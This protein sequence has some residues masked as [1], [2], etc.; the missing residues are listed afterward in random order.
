MKKI[1]LSL[2]NEEKEGLTPEFQEYAMLK[3]LLQRIAPHCRRDTRFFY[4]ADEPKKKVAIYDSKL[5]YDEKTTNEVACKNICKF[6]AQQLALNGINSRIVSC[7]SDRCRH[8]DLLLITKSGKTILFNPLESLELVQTHMLTTVNSDQQYYED[9]YAKFEKIDNPQYIPFDI[10][11]ISDEDKIH[12]ILEKDLFNPNILKT[13]LNRRISIEEGDTRKIDKNIGYGL[14]TDDKLNLINETIKQIRMENGDNELTTQM[15]LQTIL[16][17]FPELQNIKGH[18]DLVMYLSRILLPKVLTPEDRKRISRYDL[19]L[20]ENSEKEIEDLN[21]DLGPDG[22]ARGIV[23]KCGDKTYLRTPRAYKELDEKKLQELLKKAQF[24]KAKRLGI[25]DP[26]RNRGIALPVLFTNE[27]QERLGAIE[28]YI[29]DN[30][31]E[32]EK[33]NAIASIANFVKTVKTDNS[34]YI[35]I[36]DIRYLIE[37]D[38]MNMEELADIMYEATISRDESMLYDAVKIDTDLNLTHAQIIEKNSNNEKKTKGE[39]R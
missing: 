36:P 33:E 9:R 38:V 17:S 29:V 35:A 2:T 21:L 19:I 37:N 23:M 13:L 26:I 8:I 32:E 39:E 22:I 18:P 3:K 16:K 4:G 10:S 31:P 24:K 12:E 30:F 15:V 11:T 14:Y 25:E 1:D 34:E 27:I 5:E 28:N 6:M 20:P 7:D